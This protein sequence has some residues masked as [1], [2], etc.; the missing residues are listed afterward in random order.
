MTKTKTSVV[1]AKMLIEI[2]PSQNFLKSVPVYTSFKNWKIRFEDEGQVDPKECLEIRCQA[3]GNVQVS[4]HPVRPAQ[5]DDDNNSDGN[6]RGLEPGANAS[7]RIGRMPAS[8]KFVQQLVH[9]DGSSQG[10]TRDDASLRR[11]DSLRRKA[12]SGN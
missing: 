6:S 3:A 5:D 12:G 9:Q 4:V 11:R 2:F 8:A 10:V 1:R 7:R